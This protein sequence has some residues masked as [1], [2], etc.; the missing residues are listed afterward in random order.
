MESTLL[1]TVIKN[2]GVSV[3]KIATATD[4]NVGVIRIA[5]AGFRYRPNAAK[6]FTAPSDKTLIRLASVLAIQ[7]DE[8]RAC[9]RT[10]AALLLKD[11]QR[12]SGFVEAPDFDADD[13]VF[14]AGR[15]ILLGQIFAVFSTQELQ[16]EIDRRAATP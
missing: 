8:L 10:R 6:N 13:R 16:A 4:L 12:V 9:G 11:A 7:P 14:I 5:A 2:S 3:E 1:D 15:Q